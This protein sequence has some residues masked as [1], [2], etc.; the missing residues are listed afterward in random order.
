VIAAA[1]SIPAG[2]GPLLAQSLSNQNL[3]TY[4]LSIAGVVALLVL[5]GAAVMMYRK[6]LFR[7]ES[8]IGTAGSMFD[9]LHRLRRQGL[10]TEE[11]YTLARKKLAT[12]ASEAMDRRAAAQG[13][14][15]TPR[16]SRPR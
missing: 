5:A 9:E 2:A 1:L 13:A 16:S 7:A 11:E 14:K 10:M 3:T 15:S 6:R 8:D 4:L 12:R